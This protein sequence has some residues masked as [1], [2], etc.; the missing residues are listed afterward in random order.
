MLSKNLFIRCSCHRCVVCCSEEEIKQFILYF[1]LV[2]TG[3]KSKHLRQF[4]FSPLPFLQWKK[5][6][7]YDSFSVSSTESFF[8]L[9]KNSIATDL[10]EGM[11]HVLLRSIATSPQQ[12][13]LYF[14]TYPHHLGHCVLGAFSLKA[15]LHLILSGTKSTAALFHLSNF[16]AFCWVS[17]SMWS[18]L[19]R[20][21]GT[22]FAGCPIA[23]NRKFTFLLVRKLEAKKNTV[24]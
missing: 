24:F 10:P 15:H 12:Q 23:C 19:S 9:N 14:L 4:V 21:S 17:A 7:W 1:Y 5:G 2:K 8:S 11:A 22:G 6:Q 20:R 13:A 18:Q 3:S 16:M